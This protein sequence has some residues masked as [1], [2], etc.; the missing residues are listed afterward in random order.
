M[1]K[2]QDQTQQNEEETVDTTETKEDTSAVDAAVKTSEDFDKLLET[3]GVEGNP[4]AETDDKKSKDDKDSDDKDDSKADDKDTG[5][6]EDSEE[7]ESDDKG[8]KDDKDAGDTGDAEISEELAKKA[9]DYGFSDEEI[10]EFKSDE[11]LEKFLGVMDS[12]MSEDDQEEAGA[13]AASKA[14]DKKDDTKDDKGT[15]LDEDV[16]PSIA[17]AIKDLSDQN[18]ELREKLETVVGGLQEQQQSQFIKRF[19][20]YIKELGKDF[21][22]T[23]GMGSFNDLGRRSKAYKNRQT[24]GK[25][26]HAF[27]KGLIDQGLDLPDEQELFDLAVNSLHKKKVETIKGLRMNKKTTA[28][29]RQRLGRSATKKTGKMTGEQKAVETSR[30]FDELID[31]AED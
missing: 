20:G 11:E 15:E 12:I 7:K 18:K 16:D 25:R 13:Q 10:S 22:D 21:A 31:T 24:V 28:R 4:P 1:A 2:E 6:K 14:K 27:G 9:S 3:E 23:F 29:S 26:M 30:K 5:K 8:K 19:D 17:K